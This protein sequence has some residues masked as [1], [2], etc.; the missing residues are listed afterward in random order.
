MIA[1]NKLSSSEALATA[2]ALAA[3]SVSPLAFDY[4]ASGAMSLHT[5]GIEAILPALAVW[6]IVIAVAPLM[7]WRRLAS[8]GQLA[9]IAGILGTAGLEAVRIIGFRFFQTMPGSMPMLMGVLLTNRFMDGPNWLSNLLGWGDHFWNGIGFA[10]IY[11]AVIGRQRWWAGVIYAF[12][13]A[14]VFMTGP[15]MN[16]TGAGAFGQAFAPVKFPLTVYLAHLA[17]GLAVGWT[18]Q[19]AASTPNNLLTD[20]LGWPSRSPGGRA[21]PPDTPSH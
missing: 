16:I 11:M 13:I 5:L 21:R 18:A 10:F 12:A 4:S 17:F 19:R 8:A 7:G 15:V 2:V 14:T 20:A 3:A 6:I 1:F 9:V